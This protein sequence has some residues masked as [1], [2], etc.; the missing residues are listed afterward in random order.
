MKK[1]LTV[2]LIMILVIGL[3][4]VYIYNSSGITLS[5]DCSVEN[6]SSVNDAI[7]VFIAESEKYGVNKEELCFIN[8]NYRHRIDYETIH[9]LAKEKNKNLPKFYSCDIDL[10]EQKIDS[11]V[12]MPASLGEKQSLNDILRIEEWK[13]DSDD[14]LNIIIDAYNI[15]KSDILLLCV[16][17]TNSSEE[18]KSEFWQVDIYLADGKS[19][20]S[21]VDSYSGEILEY[22]E[23]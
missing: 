16:Y 5:S 11:I 13:V 14:A 15:N 18:I 2:C 9:I 4:I 17:G 23:Y 1:I 22:E 3:G 6:V 20:S 12:V 19:C 7:N 8:A 21:K 10:E